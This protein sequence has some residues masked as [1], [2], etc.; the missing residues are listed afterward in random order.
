M[1]K[2]EPNPKVDYNWENRTLAQSFKRALLSGNEGKP[3]D[4]Q[5]S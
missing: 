1:G 2:N 3:K 5:E 4:K